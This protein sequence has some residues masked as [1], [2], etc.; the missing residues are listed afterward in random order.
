[1][2]LVSLRDYAGCNLHCGSCFIFCCTFLLIVSLL[3]FDPESKMS[4]LNNKQKRKN[5]IKG[6]LEASLSPVP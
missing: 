3:S 2:G 5:T 6:N 1:M 4:I